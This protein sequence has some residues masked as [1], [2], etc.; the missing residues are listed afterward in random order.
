MLYEV[1]LTSPVGDYRQRLLSF[2]REL[3]E[4]DVSK[5]FI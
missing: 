5:G 1:R 2:T 3:G 4:G